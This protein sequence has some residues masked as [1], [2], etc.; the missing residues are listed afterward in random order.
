MDVMLSPVKGH[1]ALVYLDY[2]GVV[3]RSPH[4]HVS[5]VKRVLSHL[6]DAEVTLWLT[7]CNFFTET[8][9]Y[10][11]HAIRSRRQEI[12]AHTKNAIKVLWPLTN[13]TGLHYFLWTT[14]R[15]LSL[16]VYY[17]TYS[18][19]AQQQVKEILTDTFLHPDSC[20]AACS[21]RALKNLVSPPKL[22]LSNAQR[23]HVLDTNAWKALKRCVLLQK[24]PGNTVKP[25][26]YWSLSLAKA[27]QAIDITQR[28]C[29]AISW[30]VLM[31]RP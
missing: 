8:V 21:A 17:C 15:F 3:L 1:L 22:A 4:D 23:R 30:L 29:L 16:R 28:E 10:L 9:D 2:I 26:G 6:R 12:T 5:H 20:E 25:F 7:E 27:D 13:F 24:H 31:L 19:I 14:R 18:G 11:G